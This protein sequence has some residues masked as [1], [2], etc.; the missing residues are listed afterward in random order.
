[1]YINQINFTPFYLENNVKS[2][3]LPFAGFV[4]IYVMTFLWKKAC[5]LSPKTNQNG[6]NSTADNSTMTDPNGKVSIN[7]GSSWLKLSSYI[8]VYRVIL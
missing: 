7:L 1:M 6:K 2:R 5:L 3:L 4:V 8:G